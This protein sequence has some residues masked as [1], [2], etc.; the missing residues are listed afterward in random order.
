MCASVKADNIEVYTVLFEEPSPVIKDLMRNC[1]SAPDK[2]FDATSNAAL[3]TSF[4]DIGRKL[5][6][7]R[8]VQ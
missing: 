6:D 3:I 8:L 1:A 4:E 2:F 7:V 5:A